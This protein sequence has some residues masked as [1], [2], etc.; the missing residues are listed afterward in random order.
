M[1]TSGR[2]EAE[3]PA[4]LIVY[5]TAELVARGLEGEKGKE[6]TGG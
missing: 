2:L 1:N 6:N 4:D 3:M 5:G